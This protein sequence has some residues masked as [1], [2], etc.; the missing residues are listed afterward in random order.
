MLN[1]GGTRFVEQLLFSQLAIL[2][3]ILSGACAHAQEEVV[4]GMEDACIENFD[5][6]GCDAT[7]MPKPPGAKKLIVVHYAADAISPST[8]TVGASHGQNSQEAAEQTALQNCRRNRAPDCTVPTW[9]EN[10]CI[11]LAEGV[12]DKAYAFY[13]R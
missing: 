1:Q 7:G 2:V 5:Y 10:D 12:A 9:G 11:G 8:M 13:P 4:P 3:L 6:L